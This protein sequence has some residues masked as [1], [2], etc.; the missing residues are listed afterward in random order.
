MAAALA[1]R[2]GARARRREREGQDQ[3]RNGIHRPGR[4]DRRHRGRRCW[5]PADRVP[6]GVGLATPARRRL[7]RSRSARGGRERDP[8]GAI[9]R[10]GCAGRV[11]LQSRRHHSARRLP[12]HLGR[13]ICGRGRRVL[14][15]A[16]LRPPA[17]R[18]ADR[19]PAA[20]ASLAGR[21]RAR[22]ISAS[23]SAGIF[24]SR[25]LP[26]IRAVVPPFAGLVGLGA[27][28]HLRA[29]GHRLRHLV[30]RHHAARRG[31]R[32][33]VGPDQSALISGV[34]RTLGIA[35][36]VLHRRRRCLVSA[37]GDGDGGGSGCGTPRRM[38]SIPRLRRFSPAPTSPRGRPAR[39]P[40]CWSWS[41]PMPIRC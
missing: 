6:A 20:R 5:R 15:R 2:L 34:N 35:A 4:R 24:V 37:G 8:A 21:H 17:L 23:A 33:R 30:R 40:R 1:A 22:S 13:P 29:D 28:A 26:G 12:R 36:V 39:P 16:A 32:R 14:R 27:A 41:W 3:R 7:R 11:P 31:H 18:L 19:P 38:H 25:F 9:R 10:G